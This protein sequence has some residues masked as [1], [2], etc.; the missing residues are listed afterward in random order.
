MRW[1]IVSEE[2]KV[3]VYLEKFS[4][5]SE[6]VYVWNRGKLF[7]LKLDAWDKLICNLRKE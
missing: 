1:K 2:D 4:S 3:A 6:L 5:K 7:N